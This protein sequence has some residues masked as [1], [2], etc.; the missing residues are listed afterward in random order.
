MRH[1]QSDFDAVETRAN[2]DRRMADRDYTDQDGLLI[3][4]GRAPVICR[5]M[6]ISVSGARIR[7]CEDVEI[8][9][10]LR[11]YLPEMGVD[12]PAQVWRRDR[13]ELAVIFTDGPVT[14]QY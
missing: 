8:P 6:D 2:G 10:T 14:V 1:V 7:P 5:L 12:F 11:V 13:E 3:I 9:S 4:E